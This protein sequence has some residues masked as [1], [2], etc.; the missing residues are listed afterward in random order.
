MKIDVSIIVPAYNEED[1]IGAAIESVLKAVKETTDDYE[2]ICVDDGST[3]NTGNILKGL[4]RRNKKIKI[5]RNEHNMGGGAAFKRGLAVASKTYISGFPGDNDMSWLSLR[6]LLGAADRADL[7]SSYMINPGKRSLWR[8]IISR[9]FV[10][11]L[12]II[13]NLNLKYYNGFFICKTK[14]LK[15][16]PL[17]SGGVTLLAE[18]KIRL[19][20]NGASFTEIPFEHTGRKSGASKAFTFKNIWQTFY[21]LVLVFKDVKDV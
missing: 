12:N 8:R 7:I 17:Y 19:I 5:V 9:I 10:R 13:F 16:M 18:I 2:I 14:L 6:E 20:K 15:K 1:N 3:D 4:A 21:S 11:L